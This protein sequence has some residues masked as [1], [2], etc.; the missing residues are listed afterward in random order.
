MAIL[1]HS[2]L[3]IVKSK[4][5]LDNNIVEL[6]RRRRRQIMVHSAI[7]YRFGKNL[8]DDATFDKWAYELVNL[9]KQYPNESKT[10]EL[11][12]EFKDFDGTT[13]FNLNYNSFLGFAEYL[14]KICEAD[15][16]YKTL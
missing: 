7:Y 16:E 12:D 11:Y 4:P 10:A 2:L 3:E 6:I 1:K 14:I 5:I 13:G 8:I 9:Q 15:S